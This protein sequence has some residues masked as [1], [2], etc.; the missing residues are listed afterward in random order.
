MK[1]RTVFE[2]QRVGDL[3]LA[4]V[5]KCIEMSGKGV[6]LGWQAIDQTIKPLIAGNLCV[7]HAYTSNY[8]TGFMMN[9]ARKMA[10]NIVERDW[11]DAVVVYVSWEDT[12]EEMGIYDLAHATTIDA[13]AI[14]DGKLSDVEMKH[15]EEAAFK[16]GALPLWVLGNSLADRHEQPRM[17]LT[18]VR[19]ALA[20]L[21]K[22]MG[23]RFVAVFLDYLNL[24]PPEG[25]HAFSD[26]RRTDIMEL[27][28]RARDLSFTIGAP[29]IM[30]AQSNR[31]TNERAW[32]LP[33]KHDVM[34]SSAIEQYSHTMLSLWRPAL[35]EIMDQPLKGPD[36]KPMNDLLVTENL[37]I[38]GLNKQKRG[39]AG[40]W[41][42]LYV[43]P[44]RN[45]IAPLEREGR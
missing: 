12:V 34:E 32:K 41:W 8:K 11:Q 42:P 14:Q 37:L 27:T 16:R 7:I 17:T 9:W 43:D 23:R 45:E 24:I 20:W 2:P 13:T 26:N 40:G 19:E 15:L 25:A 28:Y 33:Q 10:R 31:I 35:S 39:P 38:L 36:G 21:E 5:R 4:E 30:G 44:A 29:V 22:A 6:S 18:Q 3:A 1:P